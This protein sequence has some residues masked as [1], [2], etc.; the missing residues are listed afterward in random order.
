MQSE[1]DLLISGLSSESEDVLK[2]AL[3]YAQWYTKFGI[4][5]TKAWTTATEQSAILNQVYKRG[6]A[7]GVNEGFRDGLCE[8][9]RII[10]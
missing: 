7:E 8:D 5:I 10:I 3:L 4:D 6:Y 2:V 1:K 9:R